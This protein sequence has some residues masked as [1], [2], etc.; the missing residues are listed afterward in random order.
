MRNNPK[1]GGVRGSI[2]IDITKSQYDSCIEGLVV[3]SQYY[4]YK[5]SNYLDK[6]AESLFGFI[7]VL[8]G[9]FSAYRMEAIKGRPLQEYLKGLEDEQ[10]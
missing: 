9:A 2:E 4:E 1:V 7:S 3:Y 8:P 5:L 6:A 10:K